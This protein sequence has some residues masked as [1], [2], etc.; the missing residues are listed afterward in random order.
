MRTTLLSALVALVFAVT[1]SSGFA[2]GR[3]REHTH[4]SNTTSQKQSMT[5][6]TN[7]TVTSKKTVVNGVPVLAPVTSQGAPIV[8]GSHF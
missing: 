8:S 6:S 7:T 3:H 4:G 1:A 2:H 5:P